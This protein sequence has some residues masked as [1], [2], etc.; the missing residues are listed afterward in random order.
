MYQTIALQLKTLRKK[1]RLTQAELASRIGVTT[2]SLGRYEKQ[3]HFIG[4]YPL[5]S[6]NDQFQTTWSDWLNPTN[7]PI[8]IDYHFPSEFVLKATDEAS[9]YL[10]LGQRI[11]YLRKIR[12]FSQRELAQRLGVSDRAIAHY[13]GAHRRLSLDTLIALAN[14]LTITPYEL[15]H[16]L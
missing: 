2:R 11:A 12:G 1:H 4:I 7:D 10:L 15:L 9:F 8:T 13:E 5:Q 16:E 6:L 14:E 3:T